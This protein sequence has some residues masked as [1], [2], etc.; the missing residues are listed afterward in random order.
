MGVCAVCVHLASQGAAM[1]SEGTCV[2]TAAADATTP[3]RLAGRLEAVLQ[4]QPDS[5]T[6]ELALKILPPPPPSFLH[7]S[8]Q[9]LDSQDGAPGCVT[10]WWS[11]TR[12]ADV[13]IING[14]WIDVQPTVGQATAF[15]YGPFSWGMVAP[16]TAQEMPSSGPLTTTS[17]KSNKMTVKVAWES[18]VVAPGQTQQYQRR[19]ASIPIRARSLAE[20]GQASRK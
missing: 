20:Q 12:H 1:G 8:L 11:F 17:V 15:K 19:R 13:F 14:R 10:N 16:N 5:G 18:S 4:C 9:V 3:P 6:D 2:V 7:L